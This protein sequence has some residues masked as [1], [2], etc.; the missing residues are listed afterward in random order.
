MTNE[1]WYLISDGCFYARIEAR[2]EAE[3]IDIYIA[4]N[5]G[6]QYPRN[7]YCDWLFYV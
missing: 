7:F 1:K 6:I 2:N 3:A 5:G 4:E